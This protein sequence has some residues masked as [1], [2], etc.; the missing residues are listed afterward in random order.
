M[1]PAARLL[2]LAVLAAAAV[3]L[4]AAQ[5]SN[6]QNT[7]N[8]MVARTPSCATKYSTLES[9]FYG[10]DAACKS[11]VKNAIQ[12]YVKTNCPDVTYDSQVWKCMS[13]WNGTAAA[14]ARVDAWVQFVKGCE[15][16]Y[17]ANRI[18][19]SE[20]ES[21]FTWIDNS[22]FPKFNDVAQ[23]QKYLTTGIMP[24]F[25]SAAGLTASLATIVAGVLLVLGLL[26]Q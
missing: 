22:C 6:T 9:T 2:L 10:T 17:I 12:T 25:N 16:F 4:C 18:G 20:T 23:F 19:S 26:Y 1:R 13:G 14:A 15:I 24:K 7:Y 8:G 21:G 5:T 11:S 3:S